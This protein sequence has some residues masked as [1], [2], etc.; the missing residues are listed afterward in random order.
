[1][2]EF[3]GTKG[4]WSIKHSESNSQWNVIGTILGG[5]YK[6]ARCPY[7]ISDLDWLNEKEKLEQLA[8]AKLISCAPEMLDMLKKCEVYIERSN[9]HQTNLINFFER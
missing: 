9:T 7:L 1:M 6:I 4:I 2:S 8:N 5:R 3:K